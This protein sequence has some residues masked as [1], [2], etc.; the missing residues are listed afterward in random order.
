MFKTSRKPVPVSV[1]GTYPTREAAS[2][3][4]DLFMKNHDLNVCANIVPS[5]KGTGYT[6]QAVK[7]Q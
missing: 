6:V 3:Q 5:E 4:V 7:W 1:V 2:R